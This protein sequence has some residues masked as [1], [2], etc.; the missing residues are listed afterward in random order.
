[1][2]YF[3]F[4]LAT[5]T[6]FSALASDPP[7]WSGPTTNIDCVS[8]HTG[9]G[10]AG[11]TLTLS[12]SN[13][14]LCQSC[15]NPSGIASVCSI[16]TIDLA[17]P[18]YRGSS[19]AVDVP[20]VNP[21]Y[22]T[23]VPG[24]T[25]LSKKIYEGNIICSTCHDQHG[26]STAAVAAGSA[27]DQTVSAVTHPS[28]AGTGNVLINNVTA[29]ASA[30]SYLIDVTTAGAAGAAR[31]RI[32]NDN[33][34]SWW[35]W[36]G[37]NWAAYTSSP[38]N[39]RISSAAAILLNDGINTAITFSAA[40]TF[41]VGDRFYFYISYPFLRAPLDSGTN[42]AGIKFCRD[43]HNSWA[44]DH[45]AAGTYDG[46]VKSHPVGIGLNANARDYDRAVPLDGDGSANDGNA[47]NNL[48]LDGAGNIQCLT[49]HGAHFADSN[50]LSN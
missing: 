7:H 40:G 1:M 27:G 38:D 32:S 8:C 23:V 2:R 42:A 29:T 25:N 15:H 28:G 37:L 44:M 13:I 21:A 22:G 49:C 48:K 5:L 39:S 6:S 47:S 3:I 34:V 10:S 12:A 50:T 20:A 30:K 45:N 46:A 33:G 17:V 35:G 24:N 36:N 41:A 16:E 4:F 19:H 11:T 31:F 43:C 9:H 14:N 18:G 26:S